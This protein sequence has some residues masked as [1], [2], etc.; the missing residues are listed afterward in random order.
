M[1]RVS[2]RH[3]EEKKGKKEKDAP[4]QRTLDVQMQ[5]VRCTFIQASTVTSV[6]L[7]V[8]PFFSSTSCLREGGREEKRGSGGWFAGT[9]ERGSSAEREKRVVAVRPGTAHPCPRAAAPTLTTGCFCA[10]FSR[11]RG[12][13]V[14]GG[15]RT[16]DNAPAASFV[17]MPATC[18]SRHAA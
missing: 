7:Y 13:M 5:S 8:S 11:R 1:W 16:K 10:V 4:S 14:C 12:S 2:R 9:V 15:Q 18:V 17:S 6:P 3:T